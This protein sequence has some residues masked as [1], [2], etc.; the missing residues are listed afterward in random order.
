ML[1]GSL[2]A[3]PARPVADAP[4]AALADGE[5]LAKGWLLTLIADAPL[6]VAAALPTGALATEGPALCSA[7]VAALASEVEL[8]RL[9]PGGDR[10]A[11][12]AAAGELAGA[13]DPA[14]ALQAVGA[15]RAALWG[16][17]I[18]GLTR[19]EP[20]LVAALAARLG[21]VCDVVAAAALGR[22]GRPAADVA[23]AEPAPPPPVRP[24]P[25]TA[26]APVEDPGL[27]LA[28]E[29]GSP[30]EPAV[31][32]RPPALTP[33]VPVVPADVFPSATAAPEDRSEPWA[34]AV[35]RR[36]GR[37]VADGGPCA[38]L[39]VDVDEAGR[40]LA[41]DVR[42]DA[43]A[44]LERAERALRDEL[45]PGDAAVREHDGRVWIIAANTGLEGARA[46]GRRLAAAVGGAA[47][48]Q[49]APLAASI[50][51]GVCPDDGT[52]PAGLVAHADEG[53]FAARAAG[54]PLA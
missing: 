1:A 25:P 35:I 43:A 47:T 18:D 2:P 42:G 31:P 26:P 37:L 36:L 7:V 32:V 17:V 22:P 49:G 50:G 48:L 14:A 19:P 24:V 51:I 30:I 34:T 52:D 13:G 46:L 15:L 28:P 27:R 12:A 10:A 8:D 53:V 33:R 29:P 23:G 41:G 3:R 40:L 9:R 6:A 38:V 39:V 4:L 5:G 21:L 16:A 44:A 54:V 11:L 20:E 45:R